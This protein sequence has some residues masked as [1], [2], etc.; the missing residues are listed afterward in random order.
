MKMETKQDISASDGADS[1]ER[2]FD[3]TD[4]RYFAFNDFYNM[5]P[6]DTLSILTH[7]KT[8]QQTSEWSC[9]IACLLMVM[10]YYGVDDYG[11][12][13]LAELRSNGLEHEGTSLKQLIEVL[14]QVGGFNAQSTYDYDIEDPYDSFPIAR[15][16]E[17]LDEG[18]PVMVGWC[19]WGGHWEVAIGYDDMGT[20]S[21]ADDVIIMA[22][23]YDTTDHCQDGYVTL[24]ADHFYSNWTMYD[25]FEGTEFEDER[26]MLWLIAT[27]K[28]SVARSLTC[29]IAG[30][31]RRTRA[32]FT[33]THVTS[34]VNPALRS[35]PKTRLTL[36]LQTE[37]HVWREVGDALPQFDVALVKDNR[38]LYA[39]V[40][41]G[42]E[43]VV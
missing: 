28:T 24:G 2:Q 41:L 16:K 12:K 9:G 5:E 27:P 42:L 34:C 17:E 4:S 25:F 35:F 37:G 21:T 14:E 3:H 19:D 18:H 43:C 36:G 30:R 26:D 40:V 1:M 6:T 11:E 32:F 31:G 22:D 33:S 8:Y 10:N 15:F 7:F 20:E 13:D 39:I 38:P 23:P 29:V